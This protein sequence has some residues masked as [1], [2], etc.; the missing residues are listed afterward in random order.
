MTTVRSV[1]IPELGWT[2]TRVV[3]LAIGNGFLGGTI[4]QERIAESGFAIL[5]NTATLRM[6]MAIISNLYRAGYLATSDF[7]VSLAT[8]AGVETVTVMET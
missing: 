1:V 7:R 3:P 2:R 8:S 6:R 5:D 4:V